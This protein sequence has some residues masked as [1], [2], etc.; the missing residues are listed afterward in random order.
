MAIS[1]EHKPV[2]LRE[3]LEWLNIRP[4]GTYVD[5]TLGGAG[6]SVEI[7]KRLDCNGLLIGLDQDEDALKVSKARLEVEAKELGYGRFKLIKTNFENVK[8]AC[9]EI[10]IDKVD[11][12]LMDI[13]V[14]SWQLD[15][16]ERG[17]S[18]QQD[19]RLDMR[20]DRSKA[21]DAQK[22][23]NEY[24]KEDLEKILYGY[25]EEKWTA[26]I[27]DFI[28]KERSIKPISTTGELVSIIKK[29]IPASAR[30]DGPHPA[31]RTFQ[32][33]RIE[34]NDELGVLERAILEG[35]ELLKPKGRICIITFHS[36][37][38]RIVKETFNSFISGCTC[39]KEFP[40]CICGYKARG[41]LATR[42]PINSD[43]EELNENPRA[44]SA[45]LRV[46]E[47]F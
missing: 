27:V 26:R 30:R 6:H 29:A 28:V 39:P 46:L 21:L 25:G 5:C 37:E 24:S 10:A 12:I 33:I 18:Y 7:L 16:G 15:E 8:T 1:F 17:F 34:V 38:D 35:F 3:C 45:K 14:S 36:L 13:G 47:K 11:G 44:R 22:V 31:K 43:E 20:M 2:L 19:A 9:E 23:V 41:K 42:K 40:V 32:A 4:D